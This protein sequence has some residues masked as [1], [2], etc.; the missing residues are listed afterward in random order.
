MSEKTKALLEGLSELTKP[1]TKPIESYERTRILSN[2]PEEGKWIDRIYGMPGA[3]TEV[4]LVNKD[5]SIYK[6]KIN[7]RAITCVDTNGNNFRS[8]VYETADGRW[9]DRAGLPIDK[10]TNLVTKNKEEDND[11]MEH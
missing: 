5:N 4:E 3:S 7:T 11:D 8:Y 6:G 2:C 9:F 10:P 1:T